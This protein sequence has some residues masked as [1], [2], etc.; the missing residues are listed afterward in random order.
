M[1]ARR[2]VAA[3]LAL[4]AVGC[5]ASDG[6]APPANVP[7]GLPPLSSGSPIGLDATGARI[8]DTDYPVPDDAVFLA[9]SGDDRNAGTRAAPVRTLNRALALVP[10]G[11]TLVVRGGVYR[12]WYHDGSGTGHAI[13]DKGVTIQ[14]YPHEQVWFD[15]TDVVPA[16][17]WQAEGSRWSTS[18]STP[19]FCDGLYYERPLTQQRRDNSGPCSHED[20]A[21]SS[22]APIAGDPQS[23]YVDGVEL[24]QKP[25]LA[26]VDARSFY[27]DWAARRLHV[28]VDPAGHT[29][30]VTARPTALVLGGAGNTVR[31]IGFRRYATNEYHNLTGV[32]LYMGGSRANRVERSVFV[33]NAGGAL[34]VSNP[35]PG[36]YVRSSVF[37]RNGYTALG[38]NGGSTA[39]FLNAFVIE[40]NVFTGNNAE[41][42][43]WECTVSCGHANVKLGHMNGFLFRDN[44]VDGAVGRGSG[45]WCDLDC[46]YGVIVNNLVRNNGGHGIYYE[47]SSDGLIASNVVV[48]SGQPGITVA[49]ASTRV[50]NNTL[51]GNQ[52]GVWTYDDAR[53]PGVDGWHDVG[54]NTSEVELVNNVV[55][56]EPYY[57][58]KSQDPGSNPSVNTRPSEFYD[59]FDYNAYHRINGAG[60]NLYAWYEGGDAYYRTPAEFAEATGWDRHAFDVTGAA[61]PFFVDRAAGDYR[62]RPDSRA[63][64]SGAP[65]PADIARILGVDPDARV[66]RGAIDWPGRR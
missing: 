37:A 15:G 11:G 12:D 51:V 16:S 30:E 3:V 34:Y 13:L 8:P 39:D 24:A 61:D 55:S 28:G 49:S 41:N 60:Q 44:I 36:S 17:R 32:A 27:Y 21:A 25:T 40:H 54:P 64:E 52:F 62:V 29:I 31:G 48:G 26:E 6:A 35:R 38:S 20:M 66:S 22:R 43:G 23:V 1:R 58:V 10:D 57:L 33:D 65:L 19:S 4:L 53:A 47:V 42:F 46:R 5:V 59:E 7:G 56:D 18:W 50:Y 9:T 63:Y 14:P 2:A 45:F